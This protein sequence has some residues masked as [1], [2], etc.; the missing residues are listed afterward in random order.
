MSNA[1]QYVLLSSVDKFCEPVAYSSIFPYVN[2][3]IEDLGTEPDKVGYYVGLIGTRKAFHRLYASD[4]RSE[5]LFFATEA[6]FVLYWSRLSDRIGRR[7]VLVI[8]LLGVALSRW[9]TNRLAETVSL[10]LRSEPI[11]N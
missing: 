6:I 9:S 7:P 1:A 2:Q 8:G 11:W 4:P 5:S 3:Q 10:M